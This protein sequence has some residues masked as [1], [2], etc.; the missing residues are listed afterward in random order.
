MLGSAC[1]FV[2]LVDGQRAFSI[3]AGEYQALYLGPGEHAFLLEVEGTLCPSDYATRWSAVL[4]DGTEKTFRIASPAGSSGPRI[5]EVGAPPEGSGGSST[6]PPFEWDAESTPGTSLALNEVARDPSRNGTSV[7]YEIRAAGF[8]ADESA[9]LW[10]KR[11]GSYARLPAPIDGNGAVRV[12]GQAGFVISEFVVG[13]PVDLAL[14]SADS[15]AFA[16]AIP[17]PIEVKTRDYWASVEVM[18]ET[19]LVLRITFGGFQPG[20]RV[21]TVVQYGDDRGVATAVASQ[22]GEVVLPVRFSP[23]DRGTATTSATGS[24]GAISIQYKVGKDALV[25]G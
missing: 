13:Q 17:F 9:V 6:Q 23:G 15:H 2:I 20:E 5:A 12:L 16:K 14:A 10:W 19:G 24:R 25:R 22:K 21:E 18:T 3:Q 4:A 1:T 11:G 8:A 7:T